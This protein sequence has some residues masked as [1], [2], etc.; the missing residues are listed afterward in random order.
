MGY[1]LIERLKVG[2]SLIKCL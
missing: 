2:A 1:N